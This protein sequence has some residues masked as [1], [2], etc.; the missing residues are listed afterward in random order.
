MKLVA[1]Y[2]HVM[3]HIIDQVNEQYVV[4]QRNV[5]LSLRCRII[6]EQIVLERNK[7]QYKFAC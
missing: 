4:L 3:A 5:K 1:D 2:E 7:H 6:Q